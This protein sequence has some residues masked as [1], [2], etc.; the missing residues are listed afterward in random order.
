MTHL[1]DDYSI[2]QKVRTGLRPFFEV[3]SIGSH[4]VLNTLPWV[5]YRVT[6][7]LRA[8]YKEWTK[9]GTERRRLKWFP[10]VL[11]SKLFREQVC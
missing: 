7:P 5:V 11:H 6:G 9:E 2:L 10:V 8:I 1:L 3:T 4:P